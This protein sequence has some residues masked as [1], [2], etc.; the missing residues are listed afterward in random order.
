MANNLL[1]R[2]G[3]KTS[4]ATA[5]GEI[6]KSWISM[7]KLG[8]TKEGMKWLSDNFKLCTELNSTADVAN[9]KDY[10]NEAW[11]NVA[12]MNYP[13]PTSFLMP[14]PGNPVEVRSKI[15]YCNK[16]LY[17]NIFIGYG[18]NFLITTNL[19]SSSAD[20]LLQCPIQH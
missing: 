3:D 19:Y 2:D 15:F 14:L 20:V 8:K 1:F 10:L 6:G 5:V 9:L 16:C 11:T 18:Y 7:N 13:Y 12:M 17:K 4:G